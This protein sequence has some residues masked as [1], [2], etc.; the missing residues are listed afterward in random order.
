[1]DQNFESKLRQTNAS[2]FI[3]CNYHYYNYC[4]KYNN[5]N[6]HSYNCRKNVLESKIKLI[7]K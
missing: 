3:P 7:E 1:M 5:I 2:S 4:R 6:D